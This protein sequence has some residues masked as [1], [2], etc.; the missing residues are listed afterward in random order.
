MKSTTARKA[1]YVGLAQNQPRFL[2][3]SLIFGKHH[4][5]FAARKSTSQAERTRLKP[6]RMRGFDDTVALKKSVP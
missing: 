1:N 2:R 5:Q 4:L 3:K 6:S